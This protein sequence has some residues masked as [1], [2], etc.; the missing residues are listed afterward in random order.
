MVD[1][2]V[3]LLLAATTFF[4]LAVKE[5]SLISWM[6]VEDAGDKA[7][8]MLRTVCSI[9]SYLMGAGSANLGA[10]ETERIHPSMRRD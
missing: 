10:A 9:I 5:A 7:A 4:P 8:I 1:R 3:L 2:A 6:V